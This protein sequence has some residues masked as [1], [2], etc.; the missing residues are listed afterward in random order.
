MPPARVVLYAAS[1][2]VLVVAVRAVIVAPPPM[3]WIALALGAYL[4]L[5]LWGVLALRLRLFVD[6]IVRGPRG[7]RGVALTFDDGPDPVWT[8]RVLDA[9]DAANV[10]AT[11]FV[12]AKKAEKHP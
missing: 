1:A 12:I 4:G 6:A 7:A 2:A 5:I 11:F 8:P 9:L 3:H 10:K